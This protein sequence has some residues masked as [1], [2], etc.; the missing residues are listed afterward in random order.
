M[1]IYYVIAAVIAAGAS[2]ESNRQQR[3]A[4]KA[5]RKRAEAENVRSRRQAIREK[6]IATS[7]VSNL[8][9][10]T[11]TSASSGV[12]G[13]ISSLSSQTAS[14][15]GFQSQLAALNEQRMG[16]LQKAADWQTVASIAQSSTGLFPAK[17]PTT[18]TATQ[19]NT[20]STPTTF[21]PF[22]E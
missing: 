2:A 4:A 21:T 5:E 19:P 14:N 9:A 20:S 16:F 1:A 13:G 22:N 10:Q 18:K 7:E 11:G 3:K 15:I 12:A 8:A 17:T 6:I